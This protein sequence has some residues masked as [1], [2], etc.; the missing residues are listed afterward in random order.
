MVSTEALIVIVGKRG[1]LKVGHAVERR[2]CSDD[3]HGA[4]GR[5]V[6]V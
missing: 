6:R 1:A 2:V 3:Q 5:E 4:V